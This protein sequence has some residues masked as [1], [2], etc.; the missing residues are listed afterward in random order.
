M[1]RWKPPETVGVNE[2]I[3]RRLFTREALAGASDQHRPAELYEIVHFEPGGDNE[4]SLDRLGRSSV[5]PKVLR[6]YLEPRAIHAAT[7]MHKKAFQGWAVTRARSLVNSPRPEFPNLVVHASPVPKAG[8]D[9]LS[10]NIY[11]AHILKPNDI[12]HYYTALHLREIFVRDNHFEP[13]A[14]TGPGR[15]YVRA[16]GR[17]MKF[18]QEV[19]SRLLGL[20]QNPEP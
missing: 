9:D 5:E 16:S 3:G 15:W 1:A 14:G 2:Y 10:E 18:L 12:D 7:L 17:A 6:N 4:L 19:W 8:S 11:H 20:G 13:I